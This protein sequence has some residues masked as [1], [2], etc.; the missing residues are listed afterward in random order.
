MTTSP[1]WRRPLH[2]SLL[3]S[4]LAQREHGE[5]TTGLLMGAALIVSV[6]QQKA[7]QRCRAFVIIEL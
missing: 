7:R 1:F 6:A 4:S 5:F 2:V 3:I